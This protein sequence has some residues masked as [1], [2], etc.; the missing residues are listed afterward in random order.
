VVEHFAAEF[1]AE[2]DR[3]VRAHKALEACA[4]QQGSQMVSMMTRVKVAAADPADKRADQHL[5]RARLW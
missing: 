2:H 4:L 5:T 3:A 1:V